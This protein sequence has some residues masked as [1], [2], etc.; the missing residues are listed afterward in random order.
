MAESN[1]VGINDAAIADLRRR[2]RRA[3]SLF[4]VFLW[5]MILG[6]LVPGTVLAVGIMSSKL[7]LTGSTFPVLALAVIVIPLLGLGG[8]ML[9]GGDRG[10]YRTALAV[11]ENV[12]PLGFR[13]AYKPE[14]SV[15]DSIQTFTMFGNATTHVGQ[16]YAAGELSGLDV[17]LVDH[18][19]IYGR[20]K[21][22]VCSEQTIAMVH[23]TG[24]NLPDFSIAEKSWLH[25]LKKL[26]GLE[27]NALPGNPAFNERFA[28][29]GR[30][31]KTILSRITPPVADLMV[32]N[33]LSAESLDGHLL[34]FQ[35]G[36]RATPEE[37]PQL[38]AAAVALA[39]TFQ[40]QKPSPRT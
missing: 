5:L 21:Y 7:D 20:G 30:D 18:A 15:L 32:S 23:D 25:S 14:K 3:R 12:E 26:V 39:Q 6:L 36:H 29:Q 11:A 28:I 37:Y 9:M 34:I 16:N 31:M 38:A 22:A 19:A 2:Q 33:G 24:L 40:K 35:N 13:Y 4:Q 17:E 27:G 1:K 8:I 10:K